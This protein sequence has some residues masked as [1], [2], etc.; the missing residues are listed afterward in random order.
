MHDRLGFKVRQGRLNPITVSQIAF[1]EFCA[2][3]YRAAVSLCQI[4]EYSDGMAL[5]KQQFGANAP[6]VAC[7]T[8]NENLHRG[9]L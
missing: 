6:D 5:I 4:V 7:S 9:K 3:I 2:R 1:E 8:D